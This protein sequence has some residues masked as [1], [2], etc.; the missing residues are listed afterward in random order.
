LSALFPHAPI[1]AQR[2]FLRRESHSSASFHSYYG[3]TTGLAEPNDGFHVWNRWLGND[4]YRAPETLPD[5][6][7]AEM[8]RFFAA[9]TATFGRPFLN[10]NNRNTDCIALLGRVLP[11]AY[12]VVVRRDP[13]YVAQSLLIARQ[14][15]QGDKS[16][17]WGLL[18]R[19]QEP[20]TG[21]L[22]YVDSVCR[23]VVDIEHRIADECAALPASRIVDVSYEAFCKRPADAIEAV[24]TRVWG[25]P[26]D[27]SAVRKELDLVGGST[28]RP[29]VSAEELARIHSTLAALTH[30]R[31]A[32]DVG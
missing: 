8:R 4:R 12:F 30:G 23:Q 32:R 25:E 6:A 27:L 28:N 10:K 29:R 22:G 5:D 1:T 16:W 15:I 7:V 31:S 24:Y 21:P 14:H 26:A 13:V 9:W 18:S 17:K 11:E 20:D 19:D 2:L 3:N